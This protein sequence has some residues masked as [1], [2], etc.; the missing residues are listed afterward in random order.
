MSEKQIKKEATT[1][2]V[3]IG[4][5]ISNIVVE[6]VKRII[7]NG[8]RLQYLMEEFNERFPKATTEEKY[9]LL[10]ALQQMGIDC[11]PNDWIFFTPVEYRKSYLNSLVKNAKMYGSRHEDIMQA[12]EDVD[13]VIR[14]TKKWLSDN[15]ETRQRSPQQWT[16]KRQLLE[17]LE[18][19]KKEMAVAKKIINSSLVYDVNYKGGN[20]ALSIMN[21]AV[22]DHVYA[23]LKSGESDI[24]Q[25]PVADLSPNS[26]VSDAVKDDD[27]QTQTI[28]LK[29][30][31]DNLK[32]DVALKPFY[33]KFKEMQ[34]SDF[35]SPEVVEKNINALIETIDQMSELKTVTDQEKNDAYKAIKNFID[36]RK[37]EGIELK[38]EID[39]YVDNSIQ[40]GEAFPLDKENA[41]GGNDLTPKEQQGDFSPENTPGNVPPN[42]EPFTA[43][44]FES[45]FD[46]KTAAATKNE[47]EVA[48][49]LKFIE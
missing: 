31:F 41:G 25:S 42:T 30:S 27:M 33:A 29:K 3:P 47:T 18:I 11:T 5:F 45:M 48:T 36:A 10:S 49:A 6:F 20:K 16:A 32:D 39:Q 40:A 8:E 22:S 28:S 26:A 35:D 44:T 14:E 12:E 21:F 13:M 24:V 19:C 7:R 43:K 2:V 4:D 34:H 9:S 38:T 1:R 15:E 46:I 17:R 37:E 23:I